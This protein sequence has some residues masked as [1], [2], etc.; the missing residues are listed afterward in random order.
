MI[1]HAQESA[2]LA[3]SEVPMHSESLTKL[4]DRRFQ[5]SPP[6]R[7]QDVIQSLT[8]RANSSGLSPW[9]GVV[10]SEVQGPV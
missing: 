5:A 8:S 2:F 6:H 9:L 7:N 3:G 4:Y 10:A 1:T